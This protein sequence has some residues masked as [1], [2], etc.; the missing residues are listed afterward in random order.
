MSEVNNLFTI[1]I[2]DLYNDIDVAVFELNIYYLSTCKYLLNVLTLCGW[3]VKLVK[4]L[5]FWTINAR[6]IIDAYCSE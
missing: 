5:A 4:C 6:Q 3:K 1:I 2:I